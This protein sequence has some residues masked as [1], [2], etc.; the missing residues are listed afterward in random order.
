MSNDIRRV[1]RENF[2]S[3]HT[4]YA[5]IFF[6]DK[7]DLGKNYDDTRAEAQRIIKYAGTKHPYDTEK[8]QPVHCIDWRER[9]QELLERQQTIL[10]DHGLEGEE[11]A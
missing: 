6:V 5:E 1:L 2:A 7:N 11:A 9:R 8:M 4:D 3:K 10:R